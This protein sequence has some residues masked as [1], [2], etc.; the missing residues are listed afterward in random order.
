MLE[1]FVISNRSSAFKFKGFVNKAILE[2][3]EL[4]CVKEILNPLINLLHVV[5]Q[6]CGKCR[7]ILVLSF[8][9]RFIWKQS[10]QLEDISN[11]FDLF[12]SGYFLFTFDL[13]SG[14][15]HVE[16]FS[17]SSPVSGFYLEFWLGC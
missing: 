5:Q 15:H 16:I 1:N 11:V 4:G 10:V 12:Q 9:S 8:L 7:L 17:R 2:L 6:P 13:K 3:I 14:Y